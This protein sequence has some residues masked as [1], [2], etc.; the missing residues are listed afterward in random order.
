MIVTT[1]K[2]TAVRT[3]P[4]IR[5]IGAEDFFLLARTSCV[6]RPY[7]E[8]MRM[9]SVGQAFGVGSPGHLPESAV[10]LLPLEA[11]VTWA[12]ALRDLQGLP[13]HKQYFITPPVGS[14][15]QLPRLLQY[16]AEAAFRHAPD[17]AVQ[18]VLPFDAH[19]EEKLP[20]YFAAGFS[21]RVVRPLAGLAP[22][23]LLQTGP[24]AQ[25]EVWVSLSDATGISLLLA[26]GWAAVELRE[27][28]AGCLLGL[29]PPASC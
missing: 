22:E 6:Y 29:A 26:R 8:V 14:L 19:L 5:R 16:A 20:A 10:L 25:P 11:D 24:H 28:K 21:L 1:R 12:A 27:G 18:A 7:W 15:A 4:L 3:A 9:L 17:S 13:R 23:A 2:P